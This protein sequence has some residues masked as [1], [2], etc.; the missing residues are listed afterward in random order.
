MAIGIGSSWDEDRDK[1]HY[2]SRIDELK[3]ELFT[4]REA[5]RKLESAYADLDQR[6]LAL[7]IRMTDEELDAIRSREP[8]T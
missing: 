7:T 8:L 5:K 1:G 3:R 4:V 6:Y 2:L